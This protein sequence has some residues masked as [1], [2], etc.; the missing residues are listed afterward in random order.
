M[1]S[2]TV[3]LKNRLSVY[4]ST[5]NWFTRDILRTM[6]RQFMWEVTLKRTLFLH[7]RVHIKFRNVERAILLEANLFKKRKSFILRVFSRDFKSSFSHMP[8]QQYD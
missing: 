1:T 8:V 2:F 4:I 7:R 5:F 3:R 6:Q